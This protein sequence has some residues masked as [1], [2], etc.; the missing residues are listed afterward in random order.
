[1]RDVAVPYLIGTQAPGQAST[2]TE[3]E[4]L[5]LEWWIA[6]KRGSQP[7]QAKT[8]FGA[9]ATSFH[10]LAAAPPYRVPGQVAI[11]T[12]FRRT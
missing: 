3:T 10:S 11:P 6:L 2:F 8:P 7:E 12:G 5:V 9:A 1:M 4:T